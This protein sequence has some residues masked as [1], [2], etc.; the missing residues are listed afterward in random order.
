MNITAYIRRLAKKSTRGIREMERGL[1]HE[2]GINSTEPGQKYSARDRR[3][4]ASKERYL[5]AVQG[6]LTRRKQLREFVKEKS[7]EMP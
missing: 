1:A 4:T 7:T 6:E 5:A 2:I 3:L